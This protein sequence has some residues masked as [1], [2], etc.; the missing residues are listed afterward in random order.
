M[1]P[2]IKQCIVRLTT[3]RQITITGNKTSFKNLSDSRYL[4]EHNDKYCCA[5][6]LTLEELVFQDAPR[7]DENLSGEEEKV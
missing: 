6:L 3:P 4:P 2:G 5:Y 7:L 1:L